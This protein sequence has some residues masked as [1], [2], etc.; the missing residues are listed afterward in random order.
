MKCAPHRAVYE[1][2]LESAGGKKGW[3]KKK[4][5]IALEPAMDDMINAA[6]HEWQCYR[7]PAT[8]Y[9]ANDK[10]DGEFEACVS[11][12]TYRLIFT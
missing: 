4:V 9:F 5:E 11:K 3:V 12:Y 7:A 8:I 10:L 1:Q 2:A 6:S